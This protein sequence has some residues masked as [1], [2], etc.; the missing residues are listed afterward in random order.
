MLVEYLRNVPIF[1]HLKESRIREMASMCK[2]VFFKKGEIV[3]HTTD[4]ST[5]LYVVVAGRLKAVLIDDAGA[6]IVLSHF[7]EGDFFGELSLIDGRGR[8]ATIVADEDSELAFLRR[9]VFLDLLLKDSKIA[10]EMMITLVSRMR[11]AD[12]LIESLAFLEVSERL[13]NTLLDIAKIE[14]HDH[15]GGRRIGKLTHKELAGRI[16][17][18]REAVSKCMKIFVSKGII[19]EAG[20]YFILIP[21]NTNL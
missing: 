7:K 19:K 3:F 16:G 5:D 1:S 13:M 2:S 15:E 21:P 17:S 11:K 12:E 14:G 8:S 20:D 18:S 10:V 6:E 9:D 4:I